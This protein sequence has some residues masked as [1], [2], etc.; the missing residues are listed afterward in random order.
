LAAGPSTQRFVILLL[1]DI[2][3]FPRVSAGSADAAFAVLSGHAS[4][5]KY[6][7]QFPVPALI[8]NTAGG[9]A[10]MD[11]TLHRVHEPRPIA[12]P[13]RSKRKWFSTIAG[14]L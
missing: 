4:V 10:L 7:Q 9:G 1:T 5:A 12:A 3:R 8:D 2:G 13:L 11:F 14:N 6:F